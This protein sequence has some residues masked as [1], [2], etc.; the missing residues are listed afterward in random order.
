MEGR[1]GVGVVVGVGMVVGVVVN[2][3]VE[4]RVDVKVGM[5]VNV[6]PKSLPGAHDVYMSVIE[7]KI[8]TAANRFI[9][10]PGFV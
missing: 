9:L 2:V 7:T 5:G 10:P 1:I 4:V 6:G 8:M 3:G